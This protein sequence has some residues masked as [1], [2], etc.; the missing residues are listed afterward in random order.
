MDRLLV[1][2]VLLVIS[3][4]RSVPVRHQAGQ[5]VAKVHAGEVEW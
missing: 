1:V 2:V 5:L 3:I 4:W